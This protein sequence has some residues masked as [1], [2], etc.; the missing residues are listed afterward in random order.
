MFAGE[1][2]FSEF[3]KWVDAHRSPD[4]ARTLTPSEETQKR[5]DYES[6]KQQIKD[7]CERL[8]RAQSEADDPPA[9]QSLPLPEHMLGPAPTEVQSWINEPLKIRRK[10]HEES[11]KARDEKPCGG[12]NWRYR[13]ISRTG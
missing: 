1:M 13:D 2:T 4:A 12:R 10:P 7:T 5:H 9:D 11:R 3:L 8:R 6:F